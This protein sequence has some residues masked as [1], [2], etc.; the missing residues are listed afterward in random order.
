ML[1]LASYMYLSTD[2]FLYPFVL[3]SMGLP[4]KWRDFKLG[5][6]EERG[7]IEVKWLSVRER[8]WSLGADGRCLRD[9]K[10]FLE[11]LSCTQL[12]KVTFLRSLR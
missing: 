4:L 8:N 11:R 10:L 5:Y 2:L 3:N 1:A 12:G 6:L 9:E 7:G